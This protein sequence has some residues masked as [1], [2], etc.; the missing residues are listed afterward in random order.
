MA[1]IMSNLYIF[2]NQRPQQQA[3]ALDGHSS[4]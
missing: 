1:H 2:A 4:L 3:I